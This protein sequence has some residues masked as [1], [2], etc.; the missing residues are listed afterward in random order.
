MDHMGHM[1]SV[2]LSHLLPSAGAGVL[3]QETLPLQQPQP[4]LVENRLDWLHLV[5]QIK[6]IINIFFI[7]VFVDKLTNIIQHLY[8]LLVSLHFGEQLLKY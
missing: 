2:G 5:G 3:L 4:Q 1:D 8:Y 7:V 6:L